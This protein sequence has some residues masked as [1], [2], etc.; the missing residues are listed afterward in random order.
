MVSA[1]HNDI[2][3]LVFPFFTQDCIGK[4]TSKQKIKEEDLEEQLKT[5]VHSVVPKYEDYDI[6][7]LCKLMEQWNKERQELLDQQIAAYQEKVKKYEIAKK[8]TELQEREEKLRFF[9]DRNK[10]RMAIKKAKKMKEIRVLS[11]DEQY[12]AAPGERNK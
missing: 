2:L 8:L 5:L 12:V 10:I 4:L 6:K 9:E 1:K 7:E 11:D 3:K